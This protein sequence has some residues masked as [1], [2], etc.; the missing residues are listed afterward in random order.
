MEKVNLNYELE[1][2]CGGLSKGTVLEGLRRTTRNHRM[3]GLRAEIW[4]G[5]FTNTN[6]KC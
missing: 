2:L 4:T 1:E 3:T 5:N 6:Q